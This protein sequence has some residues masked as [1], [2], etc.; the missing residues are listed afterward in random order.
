MTHHVSVAKIIQVL[1]HKKTKGGAKP[2][3]DRRREKL[4]RPAAV[5]SRKMIG[6]D[7][8]GTLSAADE[9]SL[10]FC[11]ERKAHPEH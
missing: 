10:K 9:V 6:G 7:A 3:V 2:S 11:P 4:G 5:T 8:T 1:S